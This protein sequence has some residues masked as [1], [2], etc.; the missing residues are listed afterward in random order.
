[1]MSADEWSN[2]LEILGLTGGAT[3][4]EIQ[5]SYRRLARAFHP[6]VNRSGGAEWRFREATEAYRTLEELWRMKE[7]A[8]SQDLF[9]T[10]LLDP[11][12]AKIGMGRLKLRLRHCRLWQVRASAAAALGLRGEKRIEEALTEARRDPD[13]RV[14]ETA[15]RVLAQLHGP[16]DLGRLLRQ[17][18]S[19]TFESLGAAA[20]PLRY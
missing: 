12:F 19:G 13:A 3:R 20:R 10:V 5:A 7:A 14:R 1:M 16:T 4:T 2:S 11:L 9:Q 18:S 17:L 6:D 15:R 8:E